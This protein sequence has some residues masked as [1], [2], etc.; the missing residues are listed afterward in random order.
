VQSCLSYFLYLHCALLS[1]DAPGNN[2]DYYAS[3][4]EYECAT[5]IM[6]DSQFAQVTEVSDVQS[7]RA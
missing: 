7:R 1:Q 5:Y 6:G 4:L 2:I 3:G